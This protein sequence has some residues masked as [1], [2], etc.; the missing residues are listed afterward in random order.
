MLRRSSLLLLLALSLGACSDDPG[1]T[2]DAGPAADMGPSDAGEQP[3]AGDLPDMGRPAPDP[4]RPDND[5]RDTDCDGLTDAEEFGNVW[6][7]GERTDPGDPDSDMD[8]LPD[9]LEAGRTSSI[10]PACQNVGFDQD[11]STQTDPT[12]PD[13]GRRWPFGR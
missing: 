8:G 6:P 13:F 11:P 3:D 4:N 12:A 7:T 5:Q 9:G 10:D 1:P 2:A